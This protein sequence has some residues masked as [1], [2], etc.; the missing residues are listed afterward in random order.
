[1]HRTQQLDRVLDRVIR[2]DILFSN[3]VSDLCYRIKTLLQDFFSSPSSTQATGD[4]R[5][6]RQLAPTVVGRLRSSSPGPYDPNNP[7]LFR[8]NDPDFPVSTFSTV[9]F[10]NNTEAL[11]TRGDDDGEESLWRLA[12]WH[13]G[14]AKLA[15][16]PFSGSGDDGH[17]SSAPLVG[18]VT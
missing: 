7:S 14:S 1:M 11:P 6:Q 8:C 9:V 3:S 13:D 15:A 18:I 17:N 12:A 4:G 10:S 2:E 16:I 5:L